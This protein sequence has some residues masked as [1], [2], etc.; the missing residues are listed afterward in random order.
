MP[1]VMQ[2]PVRDNPAQSRYEMPVDNDVAFITYRRAAGVVT[3]LHA[4]VPSR[5]SGRGVGTSL[6]RGALDLVR[7]EDSKVVPLC[8]FV[9][10]FIDR[11]V[12]YQ[13]LLARN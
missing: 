8:S 12:A 5:L 6:V 3:M 2:A 1:A 7:A 13:D 10:A 4:A 11:N 9:A